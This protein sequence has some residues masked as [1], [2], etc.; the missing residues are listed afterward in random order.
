MQRTLFVCSALALLASNASCAAV[1]ER[2]PPSFG[3]GD[4]RRCGAIEAVADVNA[5]GASPDPPAS[6][7][8]VAR[9]SPI[10]L[11]VARAIGATA[12]LEAIVSDDSGGGDARALRARES[13]LERITLAKIAVSSLRARVDCEGD[14]VLALETQMNK[15]EAKR[16]K[17]LTVASIFVGAATGIA[18]AILAGVHDD[19]PAAGVAIG[20]AGAS[21]ALSIA[22]LGEPSYRFK[23]DHP[24]NLL[25]EVWTGDRAAPRIPGTVWRMLTEE[26]GAG[27]PTSRELLVQ[28]WKERVK[29][30]AGGVEK[31]EPLLFGAGGIYD[32]HQL[33]ARGEMLDLLE[34]E[35]SLVNEGLEELLAEVVNGGK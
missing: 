1:V 13:V 4:V 7:K 31:N 15:K 12:S 19:A 14:E 21:A 35:V 27:V 11:R 33:K 28:R 6:P 5:A 23:L 9:F 26:R 29:A 34:S 2:P 10:A 3:S 24:R 8:L 18:S 16:D 30:L 20:G 25:R 17:V 22:A 32:P